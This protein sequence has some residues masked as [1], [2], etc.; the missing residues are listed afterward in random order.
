MRINIPKMRST[1]SDLKTEGTTY[2]NKIVEMYQE[3]YAK[4]DPLDV[5]LPWAGP[6]A[7]NFIN[8]VRGMEPTF[9]SITQM[10]QEA[11]DSLATHISAWGNLETT[12][13]QDELFEKY[14]PENIQEMARRKDGN[15]AVTSAAEVNMNFEPSEVE[16]LRQKIV[17]LG[18]EV[19][20]VFGRIT[21][22]ILS[23]VKQY[24][25]SDASTSYQNKVTTAANEANSAMKKVISRFDY[26]LTEAKAAY[27]KQ[28]QNLV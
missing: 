12:M 6:Q 26:W 2:V 17:D 9:L 27:N 23:E 20:R 14:H 5:S 25:E 10:L 16:M 1:L 8:E 7:G 15:D 24:Y 22:D 4:L 21:G 18:E 19:N 11:T 3:V 13:S 28:D